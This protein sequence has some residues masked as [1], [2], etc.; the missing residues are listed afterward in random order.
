[1]L[2]LY[3]PESIFSA[4][5]VP[6]WLMFAFAAG[7]VNA[8]A[9]LAC[10][11]YVTHVT[12]TATRIGMEIANLEPLLDFA[13]V[14][15]CF[16]SGAMTSGLLINGRA[17]RNKRPLYGLPLWFSFSVVLFA[18]VAGH[19]GVL[20]PFGGEVTAPADFVLLSMLSFAMGMQNAAVATS[21]GLLV[22]TTHLTGPSTDLGIHLVEMMFVKDEALSL[23]RRHA[24][25][26]AG[27][28]VS[29]ITGAA[30]AVPLA[31]HGEFLA[32]LLPAVV[33]F[34]GIMLSFLPGDVA[35]EPPLDSTKEG[36][37]L[38]DMDTLPVPSPGSIGDPAV[39][40]RARPL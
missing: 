2:T 38:V 4:R 39:A 26:R 29:F 30:M 20:G 24:A 8:S 27:K 23:A 6:S 40:P 11:T 36:G 3:K 18:A 25:L 10:Q 33:M 15:V 31:R 5:H 17:H 13:L 19:L 28:I 37:E 34:T 1:M 9:L 21:T 35:G 12:G 7:S 22:R 16:I 14:L 32:F